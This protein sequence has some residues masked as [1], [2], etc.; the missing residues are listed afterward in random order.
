[1]AATTSTVVGLDHRP[2][3]LPA[4]LAPSAN[5]EDAKGDAQLEASPATLVHHGRQTGRLQ[6]VFIIATLSGVNFLN[7]VGS[8]TL[9]IALSKIVQDVNIE[10]YLLL[11]PASVYSLAAG[12]TLLIFGPVGDIIGPKLIWL[13][14]AALYS[15]FTL[16]AGLCRTGSQLIAFRTIL[17]M[18]ISMCLPTAVSMTTNSLLP[19][20]W[21]N[22]AFAMQGMA[23]PLGYSVGV[24][25]GGVFTDTIGECK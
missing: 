22:M 7:T 11:W 1:M 3:S 23:Q 20:R 21:R 15:G 2:V 13:I 25:L 24:I 10:E 5:L 14:G 8:G 16:G 12:C 18:A 6:A 17:G 4:A 9:T 19:G